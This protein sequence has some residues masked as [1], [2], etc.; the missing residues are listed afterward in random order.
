MSSIHVGDR[1]FIVVKR[2]TGGAQGEVAV[3]VGEDDGN[4]YVVKSQ[5]HSAKLTTRLFESEIRTMR[6]VLIPSQR[7]VEFLGSSTPFPNHSEMLLEYCDA[8]DLW[9]VSNKYYNHVAAFP[10]SFI[11]HIFLQV[12]EALAFLHFGWSGFSRR[13]MVG[14]NSVIHRD[15]KP[16]NI[17]LKHGTDKYGRRSIYPNVKLGDF[18]FA[19]VASPETDR[20][21]F[22]G[23]THIWQ[24]PELPIATEKGDVWALGAIVHWLAINEPPIAPMASDLA[25][26]EQN[27]RSWERYSGARKPQSV[28]PQYS[29]SLQYWMS[30]ALAQKPSLRISSLHLVKW[31]GLRAVREMRN[32]TPL[33]PWA[34][35]TDAS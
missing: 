24:P 26:T 33:E 25:N 32:S 12:A 18:G 29:E 16:E 23:G 4:R 11:W 9:D 17:F 28:R 2:L 30:R 21:R 8:G 19:T 20:E 6:D 31:M 27:L 7:I 35:D 1:K 22:P 5:K 3:V 10:E 34:F 13:Q 15:I 14:W